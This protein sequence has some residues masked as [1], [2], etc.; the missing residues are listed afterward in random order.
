MDVDFYNRIVA[1]YGQAETDKFLRFFPLAGMG[2]CGGGEGFS[3][4]GGATGAPIKNDPD[5][6]MIRALDL[7]A[8]K[9]E[10]PSVFIAA[11]IDG[12][13]ITATRPICRYPLWRR[14]MLDMAT[15]GGRQFCL[16]VARSG[17]ASTNVNKLPAVLIRCDVSMTMQQKGSFVIMKNCS[18]GFMQSLLAL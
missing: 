11:H 6:D 13:Q 10:A 17:A 5:H 12:K 8:K 16:P 15:Q 14:N 4:I 3:H 2:H 7:W 18:N 1:K 9:D